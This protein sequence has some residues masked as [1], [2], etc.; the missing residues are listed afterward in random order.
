MLCHES[1]SMDI[2]CH[3][4]NGKQL[5]QLTDLYTTF[6]QINVQANLKHLNSNRSDISKHQIHI[7]QMYGLIFLH[8]LVI[9]INSPDE[10]INRHRDLNL[11]P[12]GPQI[13][14]FGI[15]FFLI[16]RHQN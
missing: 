9:Q 5:V 11:Q 6:R 7:K 16:Q 13:H 12:S 3:V 1:S 15:L 8:Q 4:L 14:L 2:Y 10:K